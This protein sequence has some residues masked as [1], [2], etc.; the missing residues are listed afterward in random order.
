MNIPNSDN[1]INKIIK[2]LDWINCQHLPQVTTAKDDKFYE[3][4]SC[5][6]QA[7]RYAKLH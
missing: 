2:D 3:Y 4:N 1:K 5:E 6:W 7:Y